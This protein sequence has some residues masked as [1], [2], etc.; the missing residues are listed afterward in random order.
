MKTR[1]KD[2]LDTGTDPWTPAYSFQYSEAKRP[3][4]GDWKYVNVRGEPATWKKKVDRDYARACF[5]HRR[6]AES[7]LADLRRAALIPPTTR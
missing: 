4:S 2:F 6:T 1:I 5:S 3:T 7:A